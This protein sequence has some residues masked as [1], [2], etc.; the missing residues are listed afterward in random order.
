MLPGVA[1]AFDS[2]FRHVAIDVADS[3]LTRVQAALRSLP[4][5][6]SVWL[7]PNVRYH[8]S[9]AARLHKTIAVPYMWAS[10]LSMRSASTV[11]RRSEIVPWGIAY[12]NA[13]I[14]QSLYNTG[15]GIKV[16]IIDSGIDCAT[17]LI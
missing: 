10:A 15:T 9:D 7:A 11:R 6:R 5:V 16:G 12:T 2:P 17:T 1:M 8:V 4:W 14:V 3:A 13:P